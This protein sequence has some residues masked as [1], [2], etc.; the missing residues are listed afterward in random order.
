MEV[1]AT[2]TGSPVFLP[3]GKESENECG[4]ESAAVSEGA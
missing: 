3:I 4:E 2:N 1:R